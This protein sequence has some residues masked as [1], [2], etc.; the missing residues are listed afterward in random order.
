MDQAVPPSGSQ[1][2][3]RS[4]PYAATVTQVGAT[5]RTLTCEGRPLVLG[6]AANEMASTGR[7]Q[8]LLPWPNRVE[9][10]RYDFDD[11][12]HQLSLSE[13]ARGNAAHGLVRWLPWQLRT[14]GEHT[15]T[16]SLQLYPQP[17]YPFALAV[18][19]TY[20]LGED[21]LRVRT[22]V[23][24]TGAEPAPY[25]HGA[26]PYLS[27]GSGDVDG[28]NL[29]VPAESVGEV[30]DRGLPAAARP[31]AGTRYD[32]RSARALGPV[33]IDNPFTDLVR[34]DAGRATAVLRDPE[35]EQVTELWM[36]RSYR[37]LQVYTGEGLAS[38]RA[39]VAIEPMTCPPNAFRSG[40][41]VVR[42]EPGASHEAVWG[43]RAG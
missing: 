35:S 32:F 40:V 20:A 8:V 42:L 28:L 6:F 36:D 26:H 11:R 39:A 37:W 2:T 17:G 5:L 33:T 43:I 27:A 12:S 31:V 10:G 34:D 13:P 30:D 38:P 19:V 18:S 14:A 22:R 7:G 15:V 21:G 24:N 16:A 9:D 4:G 3:L 25:G 23:T 29:T 1:T 41:D